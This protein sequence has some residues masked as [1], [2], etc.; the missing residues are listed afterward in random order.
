M[1][2][3]VNPERCRGGPASEGAVVVD[4]VVGGGVLVFA[5]VTEKRT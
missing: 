5:A 2:T 3:R 1:C 4:V